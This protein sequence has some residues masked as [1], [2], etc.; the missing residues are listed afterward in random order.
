MGETKRG[1]PAGRE[2]AKVFKERVTVRTRT[3]KKEHTHEWL[4]QRV[5]TKKKREIKTQERKKKTFCQ[6]RRQEE[7]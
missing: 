7:S 3:L 5:R 1:V 6:K 2:M 4:L